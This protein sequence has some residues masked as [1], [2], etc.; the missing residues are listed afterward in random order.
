LHGAAP[1]GEGFLE[2]E[3]DDVFDIVTLAGEERVGFL[4]FV[5]VVRLKES[6]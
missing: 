5:L 1:A 6:I 2:V 3:L 4:D